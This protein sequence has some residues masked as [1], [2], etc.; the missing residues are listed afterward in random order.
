[1]R[2]LSGRSDAPEQNICRSIPNRMSGIYRFGAYR[3]DCA[4][5]ILTRSGDLVPLQPK[6][7]DLLAFLTASE[8][9]LVSRREL[10]DS[11]WGDMFVEEGNLTFQ[12]SALR[13]ALGDDGEWLE[14]VPKFG[15]RF[16]APV[17][18]LPTEAE[19]GAPP[20]WRKLTRRW[21]WLATA[22]ATAGAGA[23]WF[24]IPSAFDV[25]T[26][27]ADPVRLTADFGS[28]MW[29]DLSP[30]G[31]QVAYSWN[32]PGEDNFDI[33]VKVVGGGEPLRLTNDPA[34]DTSPAWS[35]DG[36]RIAFIRLLPNEK[37]EIRV[38]P[39]LG[40]AERQVR[41]VYWGPWRVTMPNQNLCWTPDGL[42][43]VTTAGPTR[44]EPK[45]L[46]VV[47]LET[48]EPRR[49]KARPPGPGTDTSPIVS[50]AGDEIAFVRSQTD[51]TSDLY[52]L[53]LKDGLADG[54]PRQVTF[55]ARALSAPAWTPSGALI[56]SS[57]Y[58]L[59]RRVLLRLELNGGSAPALPE[60]LPFGE[61]ATSVC[62]SA[63][64]RL[65]YS[66]EVRDSN[67]W[68]LDLGSP[69]APVRLIASTA[70]DHT[71]AYSPDGSK[72]AFASTRTGTEEVWIADADGSNQ[73]QLT[74]MNG[75]ST[76]NPQFSPDGRTLV[77]NTRKNGLSD[78]YLLDLA[79]GTTK[80]LT[81]TPL[82]EGQP[83]WSRDGKQ[84]YFFRSSPEERQIWRM[85]ATGGEP[86]RVTE[87]ESYMAMES[88]A[89]SQLYFA[90]HN[91]LWMQP[92]LGGTRTK[93][94]DGLTYSLNFAPSATGVYFLVLGEGNRQ[95]NLRFLESQTGGVST[96]AEINKLW[97]FGMALSPDERSILYSVRDEEGADLW[98]VE[99]VR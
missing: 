52:V 9:R 1:M 59:G 97:W 7:F 18:P 46:W 38:K 11:V 16:H 60:T 96:I 17:E 13:K 48:G 70:D 64:G 93:L 72:V 22:L 19:I 14:T 90:S 35:P 5:R 45:G 39:A 24:A 71:P 83:R 8:G 68:K 21:I 10:L 56:Y 98:S 54:D 25:T 76:T 99:N 79:S 75:P 2:C 86:T 51:G 15:Y 29:P 34:Q 36:R 27:V 91:A 49:I 20:P 92:L 73:L 82:D 4:A 28:E 32:G 67:I 26:A 66:R 3:L 33:Y 53:R 62:V 50:R 84:I 58:H 12:I 40:G 31:S 37:A 6:T 74:S 65:V 30:D 95:T 44:D 23:L 47:P 87:I 88:P 43:L 69:A 80:P 85:P 63:T 57:G 61:G 78:L 41:E 55:E 89:G 94:A 42:A 77:F 81:Q